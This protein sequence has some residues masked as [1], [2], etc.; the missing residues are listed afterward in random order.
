MKEINVVGINYKNLNYGEW[1]P[2]PSGL[3]STV[4][5]IAR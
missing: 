2:V 5:L 3:N 1:P 4:K